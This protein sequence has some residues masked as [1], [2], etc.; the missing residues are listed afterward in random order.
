MS[1]NLLLLLA[2]L[3]VAAVT[4]LVSWK[5]GVVF[6]LLPLIFVWSWGGG[7]DRATDGGGDDRGELEG[8]GEG[9]DG[10]RPADPGEERPAEPGRRPPAGPGVGGEGI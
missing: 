4:L 1:R 9:P 6:F 8:G 3:A 7:D 10:R 2:G 5:F